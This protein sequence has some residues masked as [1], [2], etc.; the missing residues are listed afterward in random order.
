[1]TDSATP[2]GE[3]PGLRAVTRTLD[4]LNVIAQAQGKLDLSTLA[5]ASGLHPATALRYLGSLEARGLVRHGAQSGYQLGARLFELGSAFVR[6]TNFADEVQPVLEDLATQVQETAS[7]GILD[8]SS[9]L[10]I[11]IVQ[12]Q[13]ELGIQS[14]PGQ[15]HPAYCTSLGKAI[16]A[17]LPWDE[18]KAAFQAEPLVRLT[19]KTRVDI[20]DL[21]REFERVRRQAYAIDDEE[22][23]EGV[24][25]IGAPI[26]D[27]TGGVA[28]AIS[29][30]GPAFRV[31][32]AQQDIAHVVV[33]ASMTASERLGSPR[34][35][36][37]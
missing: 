2:R 26:F 30:S 9:V 24:I 10:Y 19:A 15:R 29:I 3:V 6:Q 25:C 28:G 23:H 18:A 13:R 12:G 1:M 5:R 27:H 17:H 8:G 34:R 21:R 33:A 35:A 31:A 14:S 11:A 16:L 4:L 37:G 20:A 36:K 7:A 22:R 32:R